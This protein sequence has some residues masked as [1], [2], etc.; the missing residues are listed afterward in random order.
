M[1][2]LIRGHRFADIICLVLTTILFGCTLLEANAEVPG[3]ATR[4]QTGSEQKL[5]LKERIMEIP[6]GT[7]IEVR[8][9]NKQKLRG[10]LGEITEEGFDLQTAKGERIETQRISFNEMKAV[11]RSERG[12]PLKP[13]GY[14]IIGGVAAGILAVLAFTVLLG[15]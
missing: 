8:L 3:A 4:A 9:L 10:R 1:K 13:I 14:V 5:T 2:R 12:G 6:P 7:M 15:G 11:K